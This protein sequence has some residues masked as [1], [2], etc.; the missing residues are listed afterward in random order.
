MGKIRKKKTNSE[1]TQGCSHLCLQIKEYFKIGVSGD[2]M[3]IPDDF[4][5]ENITS[6]DFSRI[7]RE[8]F[9][10]NDEALHEK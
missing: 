8:M 3:L 9:K 10:R 2:L 7:C 1:S 5:M 4:P 6:S